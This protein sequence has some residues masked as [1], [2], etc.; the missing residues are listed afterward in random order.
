MEHTEVKSENARNVILSYKDLIYYVKGINVQVKEGEDRIKAVFH[1]KRAIDNAPQD[2]SIEISK[3]TYDIL[4]EYA[5]MD[6]LNL[7]MILQIE[8]TRS[9]WCLMSEEWLQNQTRN[10]GTTGYIV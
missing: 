2:L 1:A 10:V 4:T 9:K 3:A 5:K 8:G 6:S 7:I